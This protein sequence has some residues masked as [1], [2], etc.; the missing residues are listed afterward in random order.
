MQQPEPVDDLGH[1]VAV[2]HPAR[3]VVS[4]VPALTESLVASRRDSV[5][6]AT[7]WCTHPAD[8]DVV[9]VRGTKNPDI[10]A[11]IALAP[12]LVVANQEENRAGRPAPYRR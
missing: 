4:L 7:D 8:L 3:R 6:A 10:R 11:I 5:I 2:S 12:D 1:V 9:R